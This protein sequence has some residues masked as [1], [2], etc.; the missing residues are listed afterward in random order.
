[1]GFTWN[2]ASILKCHFNTTVTI[3]NKLPT[4]SAITY[5][6]KTFKHW[7]PAFLSVKKTS[8]FLHCRPMSSKQMCAESSFS[9][10]KEEQLKNMA[11]VFLSTSFSCLCV[12]IY[13]ISKL[14]V[15]NLCLQW[16]IHHYSEMSTNIH[17]LLSGC[18]MSCTIEMDV[19]GLIQKMQFSI[20][21]CVMYVQP[22]YYVKK[23]CWFPISH[24]WSATFTKNVRFSCDTFYLQNEWTDFIAHCS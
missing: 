7:V 6:N 20:S 9:I 14:A 23:T 15:S 10:W 18:P 2:I 17:L 19:S 8:P 22:T 16:V 11:D 1:M 24:S 12:V 4:A 3:N 5:F 21:G 13:V